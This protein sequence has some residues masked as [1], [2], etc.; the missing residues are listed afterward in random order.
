MEPG[1][2]EEGKRRMARPEK[3]PNEKLSEVVRLRLTVAEHEHVRAQADAAGVTV[4]DYLRR[5]AVGY[6]VPEGGG[7]RA[8][9]PAIVSE[10]N[11]IGVNVNQLARAVHRG[12]DFTRYWREVGTT[13]EGILARVLRGSDEELR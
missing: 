7:R 6:R 2:K 10:L 12:S 5:R 4:S 11:R 1:R 13:L 8:G 3:D 9:D